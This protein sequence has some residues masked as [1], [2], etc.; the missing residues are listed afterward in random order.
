M[1]KFRCL[2]AQ[3][4]ALLNE[5]AKQNSIAKNRNLTAARLFGQGG[6][7]MAEEAGEPGRPAGGQGARRGEPKKIKLTESKP[8]R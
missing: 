8:L 3:S 6:T 7:G 4:Q 1:M 2:P 5:S